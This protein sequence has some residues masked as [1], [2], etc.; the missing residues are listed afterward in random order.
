MAAVQ[1]CPDCGGE[2][3][4]EDHAQGDIVCKVPV[5]DRGAKLGY[6]LKRVASPACGVL[7]DGDVPVM[8]PWVQWINPGTARSI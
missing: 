1:K 4:V 5:E 6:S 7:V 2:Q 8:A 3:F